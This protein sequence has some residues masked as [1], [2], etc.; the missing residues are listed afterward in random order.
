[1]LLHVQYTPV[2]PLFGG[3]GGELIMETTFLNTATF[4]GIDAHPTT[5]T[6]VAI[7]R[8]EDEKG[9]LTFEN[10]KEGMQQFLSWLPTVEKQYGNIIVGVEG[11]GNSRHSLLAN[12]LKNYQNIYE[13][14]PLYTKQRRTFGTKADKSDPR[15]AKLIAE[16]LT[17]KLSELPKITPHDLSTHLLV[18]RK[19]VWFYEEVTAQGV[20]IQNQLHQLKRELG[21]SLDNTEKQVIRMI[22]TE[23]EKELKQVRKTQKKCSEQLAVLLEKQGKNLTTI[24]GIK[25]I[26]AAKLVAHS[27]GIERFANIDDFIQYAGIAPKE[28]SSGKSKRHKKAKGGNRK[29]NHTL[30]L[31]AMVQLRWNPK[32]KEYFDKKVKEGK[33]KKHALKCLM[34]RTACI[35]YGM[36]KNGEDYKEKKVKKQ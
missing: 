4:I 19:T 32:A 7:N 36:L 17:R 25:T 34:K 29:L 2:M 9:I 1:M 6:A 13:V 28:T 11:G 33:T 30:Y 31:A 8:F 26:L 14:N 24:K 5:H 20:A 10:T 22:I 12:L 15:D 18:L 27:G 35:V 3:R 21:L 23:R 16:V